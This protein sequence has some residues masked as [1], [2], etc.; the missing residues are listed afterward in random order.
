MGGASSSLSGV[1]LLLGGL[2]K[3]ETFGL[4]FFLIS[5]GWLGWL[6]LTWLD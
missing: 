4:G 5:M 2:L 3:G 1:P 6:G